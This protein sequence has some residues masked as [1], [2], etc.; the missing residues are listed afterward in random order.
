MCYFFF[1]LFHRLNADDTY[2]H[3]RQ[4]TDYCWG[5]SILVQYF[6]HY[7]ESNLTPSNSFEWHGIVF[8]IVIISTILI[9]SIHRKYTTIPITHNELLCVYF[10]FPFIRISNVSS[11]RFKQNGQ[12]NKYPSILNWV[13][14]KIY[15][16]LLF[17]LVFV[18]FC[19]LKYHLFTPCD[20][21]L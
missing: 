6:T 9:D 14:R 10:H 7:T 11:K 16:L 20:C 17:L 19:V 18:L 21:I 8:S 12:T 2:Y 4:S 13:L 5:I 3:F 15:L 1:L